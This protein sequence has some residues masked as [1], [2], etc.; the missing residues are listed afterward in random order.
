MPIYSFDRE[1]DTGIPQLAEDF[2]AKI[3]E[4]ELIV[5]SFAEHN[6]AYS[7]AFKSVFD[8]VSRIKDK[9]VWKDKKLFLMVTS[10]GGRGGQSVLKIA[11][12]R[13]P[14]HGAIVLDTFSLP[15]FL[16]PLMKEKGLLL[17]SLESGMK[18]RLRN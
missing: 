1:K 7:A 6:G 11:E 10:P 8:W 3:M 9:D 15:S 2:A 4:S 16:N 12:D 17:K 13:M 18:R 5:I 14:R